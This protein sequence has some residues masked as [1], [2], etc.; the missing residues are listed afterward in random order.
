MVPQSDLGIAIWHVHGPEAVGKSRLGEETSLLLRHNK[1][2]VLSAVGG[3]GDTD[4]DAHTVFFLSQLL[5]GQMSIQKRLKVKTHPN[6]DEYGGVGSGALSEL[7]GSA[8][9]GML[10]EEE[11][12][13]IARTTT[14]PRSCGAGVVGATSVTWIIGDIQPVDGES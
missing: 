12:E 4:D 13:A 2:R 14:R 7:P 3:T 6:P 8:C 11:H 5:D 10:P 1:Q 9:P